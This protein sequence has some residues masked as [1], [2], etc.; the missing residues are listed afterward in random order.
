MSIGDLVK[1]LV[2]NNRREGTFGVDFWY[3]F[4]VICGELEHRFPGVEVPRGL[5]TGSIDVLR[6]SGKITHFHETRVEVLA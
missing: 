5:G 6:P 4:G 1:V 2:G 3:E